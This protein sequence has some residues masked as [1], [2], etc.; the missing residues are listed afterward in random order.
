MQYSA[1]RSTEQ[2]ATAKELTSGIL[3]LV[4]AT[5]PN[6]YTNRLDPVGFFKGNGWFANKG[7]LLGGPGAIFSTGSLLTDY[8]SAYKK[9]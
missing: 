8:P 3:H 7:G 2:N 1:Y 6:F 5:D 4:G 9:K